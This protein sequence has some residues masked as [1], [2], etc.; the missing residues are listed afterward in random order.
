MVKIRR[1][2]RVKEFVLELSIQMLMMMTGTLF[3]VVGCKCVV[4][5]D[6]QFLRVFKSFL[7]PPKFILLL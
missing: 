5:N 6:V 2:G 1:Q 4:D 7:F 3:V